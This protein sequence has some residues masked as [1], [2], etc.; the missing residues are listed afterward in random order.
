[1]RQLVL[2]V[3][4]G[5][6]A[7]FD[8][9][10]VGANQQLVAYLRALVPHNFGG[11]GELVYLWG[12][13]GSGKTHLLQAVTEHLKQRGATCLHWPAGDELNTDK[14]PLVCVDSLD[15]IKGSDSAQQAL[16]SLYEQVK[17]QGGLLLIAASHP[18][19]SMGLDLPDLVSRLN[20]TK[21]F[22]VRPLTDQ[23]KREALRTR[24]DK[25][26]FRLSP[27]VLNWLL[28]HTSRDMRYLFDLLDQVD[29]ATLVEQRKVT[30]PLIKE[31]MG[32]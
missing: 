10:Y 22:E 18:P 16:L 28:A 13:A 25:R 2:D 20:A 30:V 11:V 5:D 29:V 19:S 4:R 27:E 26:G 17:H 15:E 14:L 1:M 32:K 3:R 23:Q 21:I 9:F 12:R 24:A 31:L 7:S 6:D 8:N